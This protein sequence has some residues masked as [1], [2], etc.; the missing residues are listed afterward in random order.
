MKKFAFL[1]H[2]R[3]SYQ[4]DLAAVAKPLGWLPESFY[5]YAF[6]NR[7]FPPFL[8]SNITLTPNAVEPQGHVI[9]IPYSGQQMLQQQK[10]MLPRIEQGLQLAASLGAEIVG[11]GAL[12]SPVTMGGKL[13]T[14]NPYA[15]ITNGNAFTAVITYQKVAQ[16]IQECPKRY[17]VVALVG[18]TG[19]VGS[20]VSQLLALHQPNADYVLVARNERKLRGLATSMVALNG[21][22]LPE[23]AL[24]ME[25]VKQADIVVMLTS[26]A[27]ALLQADHLKPGAVVL[28]DTIP[29]NTQPNLL[30]QRPDVTIIDGGLVAMPHLRLSRPIGIPTQTSYACLAETMLLALA[31]HEGH[32]SIGNPTLEQADYIRGLA[33]R[34]AHL[35]FCPAADYSFGQPVDPQTVLPYIPSSS[36]IPS[37]FEPELI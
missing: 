4:T 17:P 27:D 9:M 31:G 35:G 30:Q 1:V 32:F 34:F 15:S 11:L 16:L 19:S 8:W 2:V 22:V 26:S 12:T 7:P 6:R 36:T 18:A 13:L 37:Y 20:L 5:Q 25:R 33:S 21:D 3:S 10:A 28:D 14:Q 29:R 24:S 23:I